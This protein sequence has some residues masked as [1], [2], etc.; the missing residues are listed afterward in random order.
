ME[1]YSD[2]FPDAYDFSDICLLLAEEYIAGSAFG[3]DGMV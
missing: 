3:Y 2:N 1:T